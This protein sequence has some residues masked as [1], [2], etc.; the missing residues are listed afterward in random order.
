VNPRARRIGGFGRGV[1]GFQHRVALL[2]Q[3]K[4]Q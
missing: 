4:N 1:I 2:N 3:K